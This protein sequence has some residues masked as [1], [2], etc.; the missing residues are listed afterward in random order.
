[1]IVCRLLSSCLGLINDSLGGLGI[2]NFSNGNSFTGPWKLKEQIHSDNLAGDPRS[3][4]F[5][6]TYLAQKVKLLFLT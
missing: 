4:S 6:I 2:E 3:G 1:M 5:A